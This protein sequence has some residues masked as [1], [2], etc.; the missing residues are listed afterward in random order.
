VRR[1]ARR[2]SPVFCGHR[3]ARRRFVR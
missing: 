3:L 1:E 2:R